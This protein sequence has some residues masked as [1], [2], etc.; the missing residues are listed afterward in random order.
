MP[1]LLRA[2]AV[3][4]DGEDYDDSLAFGDFCLR[5][6]GPSQGSY[7]SK[8]C[9]R[10]DAE[11]SQNSPDYSPSLSALPAL[12]SS[13]KSVCSTP[14]S[15]A[16]NS[17]SPRGIAGDLGE[18]PPHLDLPAPAHKFPYGGHSLP[19]GV[20]FPSAASNWAL[21]YNSD[22]SAFNDKRIG[23]PEPPAEQLVYHR[24][25]N[26]PSQTIPAPLYYRERAAIVHSSPALT[27]SSPSSRR[28][29]PPVFWSPQLTSTKSIPDFD[30][31]DRHP[32]PSRAL[33]P[34]TTNCGRPGCVGVPARPQLADVQHPKDTKNRRKSWTSAPAGA[35]RPLTS[36]A[37]AGDVLMS[38][39]IR[40]LRG[41]EG[42]LGAI[43]PLDDLEM[44]R[45]AEGEEDDGRHSAFACYLFS[46]LADKAA[47]VH[48]D[49]EEILR[50]RSAVPST[51]VEEKRSLSVD[52]A[53]LARRNSSSGPALGRPTRFL[54]SRGSPAPAPPV[55]ETESDS[56]DPDA[57]I[58]GSTAASSR[59]QLTAGHFISATTASAI[60]GISPFPSPPPS[61][62]TAGRGRSTTRFP[63]S[64][65]EPDG[66]EPRGRSNMRAVGAAASER[67]LSRGRQ[68]SRAASDREERESRSRRRESNGRESRGR[69]SR[70]RGRGGRRDEE[71]LQE[72]VVEEEDEEEERGRARGRSRSLLRRGMGREVA[73]SGAAYGH[74]DSW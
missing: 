20:R 58:R 50:G 11:R 14:P 39:R 30:L 67:S 48:D 25:S 16:N 2:P 15:S 73:I 69:E 24:K 44:G 5:C 60:S 13:A 26:K 74:D 55:T 17:P 19:L 27:P 8:E 53:A 38:P 3:E 62:P 10:S 70:G 28:A 1:A 37:E 51:P 7:C 33:P 22:A 43:E 32:P 54:F 52:A 64:F 29:T 57:T 45:E 34:R 6:G 9:R 49:M 56:F 35:L 65:V 23:G 66:F 46:Q 59:P 63:D 71:D 4:Y 72:A 41:L 42:G 18:E 40:A 31:E 61:P 47:P 36:T 21:S 68:S 12:V